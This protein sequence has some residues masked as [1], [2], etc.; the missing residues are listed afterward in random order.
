ME[1]E[2]KKRGRPKKIK[3]LSNTE[4]IIIEKKKRG[5][6]KKYNPYR[7]FSDIIKNIFKTYINDYKDIILLFLSYKDKNNRITEIDWNIIYNHVKNIIEKLSNDNI[8]HNISSD[9]HYKINSQWKS[10]DQFREQQKINFENYFYN[11]E[12]LNSEDF[13]YN[14]YM[15]FCHMKLYIVESSK[16]QKI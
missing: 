11:Y 10:I 9:Y 14:G 15:I 4:N 5:R 6:P 1:L 2:K 3:D 16:E 12:K 13:I 8:F 7:E